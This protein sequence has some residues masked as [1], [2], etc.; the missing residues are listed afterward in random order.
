MGRKRDMRLVDRARE[1][2][3]ALNKAD[4]NPNFYMGQTVLFETGLPLNYRILVSV[5]YKDLGLFED[6]STEIDFFRLYRKHKLADYIDANLIGF[7]IEKKVFCFE[8]MEKVKLQDLGVEVI[9][10][11]FGN[12]TT[13]D[14]SMKPLHN[15]LVNTYD[16]IPDVLSYIKNN[17]QDGD[18]VMGTH[19][20]GGCVPYG[21]FFIDK[22]VLSSDQETINKAIMH[23]YNNRRDWWLLYD[24]TK[25][26]VCFG[27]RTA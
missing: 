1:N 25:V 27:S 13:N 5:I 22:D 6:H 21:V 26:S 4:S 23:S 7:D 10:I 8:H 14:V 3:A 15:F 12:F 11:G 9:S 2:L 16:D 19:I 20:F 24:Y 18:S 17:I